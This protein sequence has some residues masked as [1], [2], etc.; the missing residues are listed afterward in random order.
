MTS[1]IILISGWSSDQNIWLPLQNKI[2]ANYHYFDW[3]L[4]LDDKNSLPL[5]LNKFQKV[6]IISWSL[7]AIIALE[8][9]LLK[10]NKIKKLILLSPTARM[11]KDNNYPGVD[12]KILAAMASKLNTQQQKLINDFAINCFFPEPAD[13]KLT[14]MSSHFT[15]S[16]LKKGLEFLNDSDLRAELHKIKIPALILHGN[17]DKIIPLTQGE[18]LAKNLTVSSFKKV[19]T[20]HALP[21][22]LTTELLSKIERFINE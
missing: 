4:Y 14:E 18:Y 2:K 7:G 21:F 1:E 16:E 13:Q 10:T 19:N 3:K 9:A 5:F 6:V 8:A 11:T 22:F 15:K 20:G 17:K 12:H